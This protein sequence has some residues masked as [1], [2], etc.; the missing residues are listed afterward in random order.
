MIYLRKLGTEIYTFPWFT[1]PVIHML[2]KLYL[3]LTVKLIFYL[4][5]F[6]GP[7]LSLLFS[8]KKFISVEVHVLLF[9][10]TETKL[11]TCDIYV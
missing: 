5:S 6:K 3:V 8:D 1:F 9:L 11:F 2:V 7:F 10:I 4:F